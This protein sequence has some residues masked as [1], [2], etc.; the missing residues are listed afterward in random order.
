MKWYKRK[1]NPLHLDKVEL[2]TD[3]GVGT[4]IFVCSAC[5][6]FHPNIPDEWIV[7]ITGKTIDWWGN[8]YLW[9]TKNPGRASDFFFPPKSILCAIIETNRRYSCMGTSP[10]PSKRINGLSLWKKKR[11]ITIEPILDFDLAEFTEMIR[12]CEPDQ[13]NI[14]ADTGNNHLPEPSPEKIE[15]IIDALRS[16][17]TVHLK[18]N[19]KRLYKES[20]I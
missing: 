2:K 19:L 12:S 5:D 7:K 13:V 14:G 6:L 16:F 3:M 18:K 4:F 8:T 20:R 10:D 15:A 1:Q 11:M 17:T 9:H